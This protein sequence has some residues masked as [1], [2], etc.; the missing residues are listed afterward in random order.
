M[1]D[2][3]YLFSKDLTQR[4]VNTIKQV[5]GTVTR[6]SVPPARS[7]RGG[8]SK[9]TDQNVFPVKITGGSNGV[10]IAKKV[11]YTTG[12][13]VDEEITI[14]ASR[15]TGYDLSEDKSAVGMEITTETLG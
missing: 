15:A 13:I 5:S 11:D 2:E 14:F 4:T 8:G 12:E 9:A 6:A 7:R 10:Y 3:G 1:A